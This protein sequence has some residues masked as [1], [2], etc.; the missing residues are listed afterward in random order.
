MSALPLAIVTAR[1]LRCSWFVTSKNNGPLLPDLQVQP[2]GH[3][4]WIG[5]GDRVLLIDDV[6]TSG[7]SLMAC[8]EL[9]GSLG[10]EVVAA[11]AL[12]DRAGHAS[13]RFSK[14]GVRLLKLC[15]YHDLG[16][17]KVKVKT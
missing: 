5:K 15:D 12:V 14:R 16:I 4:A 13:H 10:G 8:H 9:V 2:E 7:D 3:G 1:S 6:V 11:V 17:P